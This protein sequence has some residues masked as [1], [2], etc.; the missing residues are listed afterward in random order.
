MIAQQS[1]VIAFMSLP[2]LFAAACLAFLMLW[3]FERVRNYL[4]Y[5]ATATALFAIGLSL[6][7]FH[8]GGATATIVMASGT[9]Y[10][11]CAICV[12]E[13]VLRRIGRN[14]N[15]WILV[16]VGSAAIGARAWFTYGEPDL[17]GRIYA[18]SFGVSAIML[19]G[20]YSMRSQVSGKPT[21][22]LVFWSFALFAAHLPL[23][24]LIGIWAEP[25]TADWTYG[26]SYFWSITQLS[27]SVLGCLVLFSLAAAT[28]SDIL[29]QVRSERDLDALTGLPNRRGFMAQAEALLQN[30]STPKALLICDI[31]HFKKVNDTHGHLVGDQV[32]AGVSDAIREILRAEDVAGRV[33][34]EEFLIL[35]ENVTRDQAMRVA[36]R[37]RAALAARS[38][39]D[40]ARGLRITSSIGVASYWDG[41]SIERMFARADTALYEAKKS[42]RNR[43]SIADMQH[44]VV[45]MRDSASAIAPHLTDPV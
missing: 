42:G 1:G 21:D 28:L 33:G 5:Y 24:A 39:G 12:T 17:V 43:V 23:R 31:D 27:V 3:R 32:L 8:F 18:V 37:L 20:A 35:L 19:A 14:L 2:A 41:E 30:P 15:R 4:L 26:Q 7:I 45:A 40:L 16:L 10:V 44:E 22:R 29:D 13:G 6:Q 38:Y 9:L 36:E 11:L 34:G 25:A